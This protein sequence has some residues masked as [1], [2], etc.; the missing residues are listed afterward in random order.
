M[1]VSRGMGCIKKGATGKF[2]KKPVALKKV[3]R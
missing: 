1:R 2:A 3:A